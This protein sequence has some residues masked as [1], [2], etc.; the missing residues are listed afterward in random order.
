LLQIV[1]S[2]NL[3]ERYVVEHVAVAYVR[4]RDNFPSDNHS[5]RLPMSGTKLVSTYLLNINKRFSRA[6]SSADGCN[7]CNHLV[8]GDCL[9]S[10]LPPLNTRRVKSASHGLRGKELKALNCVSESDVSNLCRFLLRITTDA[11]TNNQQKKRTYEYERG[12][13]GDPVNPRN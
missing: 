11:M 6:T 4:K 3:A 2:D 7:G 12:E 8:K 13:V 5:S 10:H 1:Y 9:N